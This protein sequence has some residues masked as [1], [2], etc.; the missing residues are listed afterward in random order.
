MM[1]NISIHNSV[2]KLIMSQCFQQKNINT[3]DVLT[4]IKVRTD[5]NKFLQIRR[6]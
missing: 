2:K 4:L 6:R 3:F 1:M 5:E